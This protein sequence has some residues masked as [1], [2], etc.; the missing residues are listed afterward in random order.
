M[1]DGPWHQG[2]ENFCVRITPE[3]GYLLFMTHWGKLWNVGVIL[4]SGV[5]KPAKLEERDRGVVWEFD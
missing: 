2:W 5:Q 3:G 1:C 4:E